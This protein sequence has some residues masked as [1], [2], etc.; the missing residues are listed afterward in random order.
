MIK[1]AQDSLQRGSGKSAKTLGLA[2]LSAIVFGSM[3]GGGIFNIAQNL[4]I[5]AAQGGVILAWTIT[6][7]GMLFLVFTFRYL[8]QCRPDLNAGIY[9]YAQVG[10]GNY[11][12]FNIAWGYWLCVGFAN[13]AYA[14]MLAKSF[15]AFWAPLMSNGWPLVVFGWGVIWLMCIVV[16]NGLQTAAFINTIM[17]CI[18]FA[19]LVLICV[20]LV[21]FFKAGLFSSDFWGAGAGIGNVEKQIENSMLVTVWTFIGIET[22]VMMSSRA[23]KASDVGKSAVIG[24]ICAWVLYLG[25]SI[26][27]YGVMTRAQMAGLP[28]PSLAYVLKDIVGPWAYY[29]V[30]ISVIISL[31]GGFVAWTLV[32]AQTPF[33]AAEAGILPRKFLRLNSKGMPAYGLCVSSVV[34]SV[35]MAVVALADNVYMAALWLTSLMVAPAYMLSGMFLWKGSLNPGKYL[36]DPR[37][38]IRR[39]YLIV[40][41]LCTLFCAW[42]IYSG[43]LIATLVTSL[44][45]LGGLGFY[46]Q[47]RRQAVGK[48]R[49]S[50]REF[51]T[52]WETVLFVVLC[53]A[54]VA[55]VVLLVQGKVPF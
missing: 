53:V 31:F 52:P 50:W 44:F 39:K 36:H 14:V 1:N 41:I 13:V 24:F 43:G 18:K 7:V 21:I 54:A 32:C 30:I 22:S 15:G 40:G 6:A 51:L 3:I 45:Y 38:A 47:A 27:C 49:L 34:M 29:A 8:S 10:F 48:T 11:V 20:V 9:Q 17:S 16:C 4:A 23:R 5:G 28:D 55:S 19:S 42:I 25:I 26:L 37:G 35:L 2:G 33:G 12:G 46:Y